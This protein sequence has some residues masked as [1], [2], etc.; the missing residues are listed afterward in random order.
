MKII[1]ITGTLGA[2]KGTIVDYL[3][4]KH[5]FLH[6]SARNFITQEMERRGLE[7]NRDNMTI[8][9]NDLRAKNGAS[10]ITDQLFEIAGESGKDCI[11]ESIRAVGEI[12][13][14]RKKGNF[15][16]F[17]VDADIHTRYKRIT[18]RN[19]STDHIDFETFKANEIRE[20]TSNNPFKQNLSKCISMADFIF[21]NNGDINELEIQVETVLKNLK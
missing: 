17:A 18:Q 3:V 6:L 2:G 19:S 8:T 10:Y 11:I 9:A 1:G 7:P 14:L 21:E 13:S 4:R 16:L 15:I 5:G 12:E 20:M